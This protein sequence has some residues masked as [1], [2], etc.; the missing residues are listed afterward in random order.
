ML[1]VLAAI[2]AGT[3]YMLAGTGAHTDAWFSPGALTLAA[4]A[5]LALHLSGIT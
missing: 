5:C 2:L 3:G 1:A 4:I